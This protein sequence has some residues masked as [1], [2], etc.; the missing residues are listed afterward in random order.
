MGSIGLTGLGSYRLDGF[1][2]PSDTTELETG[3]ASENERIAQNINH[4]IMDPIRAHEAR[5]GTLAD[6]PVVNELE[7]TTRQL[8]GAPFEGRAILAFRIDEL[9]LVVSATVEDSSGDRREWDEVAKATFNALA[10][11]RVR[12]P[13]GSKGIAM[14][15]EITAQVVLPSG[16]RHPVSVGSPSVDALGHVL[17]GQFDRPAETPSIAAMTF[18]VSD[19]GAHPK[20]VA[21]A[22][23]LSETAY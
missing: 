5:N 7:R 18:D 17:Q 23:V 6:G 1:R 3:T 13:S 21:S 11:T 12:L 4:A 20:R 8:P 9:G 15:V 10:Q 14:R 19:I 16:A 22:R 2:T